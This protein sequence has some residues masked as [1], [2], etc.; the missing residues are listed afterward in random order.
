MTEPAWTWAMPD[1][2]GKARQMIREGKIK[3]KD[4][5]AAPSALSDDEYKKLMD[6]TPQDREAYREQRRE[7]IHPLPE[8]E[9]TTGAEVWAANEGRSPNAQLPDEAGAYYVEYSDEPESY[10]PITGVERSARR[11]ERRVPVAV[12]D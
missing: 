11:A 6:G 9:V 7:S 10:D 3:A 8:G 12:H 5:D 2:D 4:R 1:Y